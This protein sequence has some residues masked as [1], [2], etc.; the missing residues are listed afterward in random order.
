MKKLIVMIL[1]FLLSISSVSAIGETEPQVDLKLHGNEYGLSF[2]PLAKGEIAILHLPN[3][4]NYLINTGPGENKKNLYSVLR[5][6]GAKKIQGIIVTE[7]REYYPEFIEEIIKDFKVSKVYMGK[8]FLESQEQN[9]LKVIPLS[10]NEKVKLSNHL[11]LEVVYE[12]AAAGEGLDFKISFNKHLFL[13]LSSYTKAVQSHLLSQKLS[14]VN[15]IKIPI[16]N[17]S[18]FISEELL[19]HIDP[20]TAIL[21]RSKQR[22]LNSEFL[23]LL[24]ETWIDIYLTGQHGLITIKFNPLNY[25]VI[26]FPNDDAIEE[27]PNQ[28]K[29]TYL[30]LQTIC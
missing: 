16:Y 2:L 3:E 9:R 20:Q 4:M 10:E 25:E 14:D 28:I 21:Y 5:Q 19:K 27:E 11:Q 24:H 18:N 7:Q 12:G 30:L 29:E 6:F 17:K 8:T 26:T 22:M 15:I 13:W 23:E 1:F